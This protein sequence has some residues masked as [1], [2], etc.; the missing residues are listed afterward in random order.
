MERLLH[1][2]NFK[3]Q[4]HNG[5]GGSNRRGRANVQV[6]CTIPGQSKTEESQTDAVKFIV[7]N[8]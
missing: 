3:P 4:V 2:F 6:P 5:S 1:N 7:E 8:V